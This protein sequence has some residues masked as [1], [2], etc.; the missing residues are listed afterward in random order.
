MTPEAILRPTPDPALAALAALQR[1]GLRAVQ[2]AQR[3]NTLM[4]VGRN[5]AVEHIS[6]QEYLREREELANAHRDL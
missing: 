6:P 3:T 5:G 1:A 4:V 2:E